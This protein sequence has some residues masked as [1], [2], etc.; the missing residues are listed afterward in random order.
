MMRGI[1]RVVERNAVE[2]HVIEPIFEA[3]KE[4]LVVAQ[5]GSIGTDAESARRH[6][7]DVGIIS[8]GRNEVTDVS[9]TDN[10]F[11]ALRFE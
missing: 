9:R 8:G 3:A 7:Q 10:G 11:R 1:I 6:L 2:R 5:A 4:G